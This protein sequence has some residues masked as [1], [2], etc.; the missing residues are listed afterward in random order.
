MRGEQ[1]SLAASSA[2]CRAPKLDVVDPIGACNCSHVRSS[3][4]GEPGLCQQPI[5]VLA[6]CLT[7]FMAAASGVLGVRCYVALDGPRFVAGALGV[8]FADEG[9]FAIA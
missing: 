1:L 2:C 7:A 6:N 5:E 8:G 9:L 4:D 3:H